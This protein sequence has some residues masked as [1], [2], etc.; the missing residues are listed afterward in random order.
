MYVI[1]SDCDVLF[2]EADLRILMNLLIPVAAVWRMLGI[3]LDFH[4]GVLDNIVAS[5]P[6]AKVRDYLLEL[7]TRWIGSHEA[8]LS[9]LVEALCSEAVKKREVARNIE[10]YYI[11]PKKAR[12]PA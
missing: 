2:T 11:G 3:Q 5:D 7:L 10:S 8:K 4:P 6:K 1:S 9:K 12:F